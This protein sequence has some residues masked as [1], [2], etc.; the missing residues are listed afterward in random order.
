MIADA[1]GVAAPP[2][3]DDPFIFRTPP[4]VVPFGRFRSYRS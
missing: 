3:M 1:S 4:V 2:W